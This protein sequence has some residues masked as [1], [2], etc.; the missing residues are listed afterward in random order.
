MV[1]IIDNWADLCVFDILG[2]FG[3]YRGGVEE[4][5]NKG[6]GCFFFLGSFIL[7]C[8]IGV[9]LFNIVWFYPDFMDYKFNILVRCSSVIDGFIFSEI[10]PLI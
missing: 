1:C 7:Y 2:F 10:I 8:I 9:I 4:G 5:K 3:Y 6:V